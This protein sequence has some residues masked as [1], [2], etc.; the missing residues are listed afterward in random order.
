MSTRRFNFTGAKRIRQS[1][2]QIVV[3]RDDDALA[4]DASFS[5]SSYGLPETAEVVVEA[6]A[7]WILMRFPFGTVGARRA[8]ESTRLTDF[9]GPEGIRFR[10]KVL[11]TGDHAGLILAEADKLSPTQPTDSVSASSFIAVRPAELGD[12]VWRLSFDEAQP[13]LSINSAL[14]DWQ[15]FVRRPVVRS[16]LFPEIVRQV[17]REALSSERDD[18]DSTSWQKQA[19]TLASA[20]SGRAPR[21]AEDDDAIELWL[22]DVVQ[23]FARQHRLL[24]GVMDF[25]A[26]EAE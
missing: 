23:R 15:S 16:L 13:V 17:V 20:A 11:G 2:V 22:D 6:Y 14:G 21:N 19:L 18:D 5:I 7:E 26:S 24:R 10:L 25:A 9:D 1:D 3:D 8:P 4:F 12:V